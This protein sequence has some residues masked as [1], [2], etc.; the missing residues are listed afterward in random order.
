MNSRFL[1]FL[2]GISFLISCSNLE[3]DT[4]VVVEDSSSTIKDIQTTSLKID[5]MFVDNSFPVFDGQM[6][7]IPLDSSYS[8]I[9]DEL[10]VCFRIKDMN[11]IPSDV[12]P[13]DKSLF[14]IVDITREEKESTFAVVIRPG[15][16]TQGYRLMVI[17]KSSNG[18]AV[19]ND[20]KGELLEMRSRDG[21][22]CHDLFIRYKD[23]KV[24]TIGVIHQWNEKSNNYLPI[25][26]QE[27]NDFYV[28]K[29]IQDSLNKVYI[30]NFGWGF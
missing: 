11:A 28:K 2:F 13:C 10:G 1:I 17:S 15:I 6:P 4:N 23:S 8:K 3:S 22:K 16:T 29:S 5:T 18:Y 25:E 30:S 19:A 9:L 14:K 12:I 20:Y 26:V 24:G 21:I 7:I 27:I